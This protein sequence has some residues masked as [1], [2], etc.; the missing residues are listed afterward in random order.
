MVGSS[1]RRSLHDAEVRERE[2]DDVALVRGVSRIRC[3][4]QA[5][6]VRLS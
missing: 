2:D 5:S 6:L 1:R 3:K 4:D